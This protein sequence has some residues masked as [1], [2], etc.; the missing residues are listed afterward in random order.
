MTDR[1]CACGCGRVV[2]PSRR[3]RRQFTI[4]C[5]AA[6]TQARNVN[7]VRNTRRRVVIGDRAAADIEQRFQIAKAQIAY[8]RKRQAA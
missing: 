4:A 5:A 6:R 1:P 2:E 7:A 3:N 8:Q